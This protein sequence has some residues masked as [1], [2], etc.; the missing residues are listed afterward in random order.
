MAAT[1]L[2]VIVQGLLTGLVYGLMALGLSVIFGVMRVVNFAH[3]EF[4]VVAMYAAFILFEIL[5]LDPL[6]ALLPVAMLFFGVGYLLQRTLISPFIGRAEHEQFILLVGLATVIVNGLLMIFGPDARPINLSYSFDSYAVGGIFID[7]VRV[8]AAI[9]RPCGRRGIVPVLSL[10]P[11]RNRDPR[12]R[13]QPHGR[14]GGRPQC[15]AALRGDL[16]H[17][18]RLRRR[19]RHPDGDHRRCV[20]F[21]G[22]GL[23]PARLHHCDRRRARIDGRRADRRHPDRRL[24]STGR[25]LHSAVDEKHVLL[26]A[27]DHRAGAAS[28][29]IDGAAAVNGIWFRT[30]RHGKVLGLLLLF[31]FVVA[32]VMAD[33]YLLSV[34]ILVFYFAYLGQAWN[35]LMGFAGQLSLGH[36]LYLG[37]GAYTAT[38]L[39]TLFGIGPWLGVFVAIPVA[40]AAGLLIGWLGWRFAIEGV[41]FALLT[42]AF[43]EF[44]RIGF[45]N[46][47]VTGGAGG[48]FLPV[49]G[50]AAG[51]WWNLGGGPLL[52]YY[53]SLTLA[54]RGHRADR[55]T[56]PVSARL[57]LACRARGSAG[58]AGG[59]NQHLPRPHAGD[60]DLLRHDGGRR[61]VLRI[62]LSQPVS[63][64]GVRHQPLD[65]TDPGA[66]HWRAWYRVR[67]DR[68][69]DRADTARR[70]LDRPG[71]T[72]GRQ[73]ARRQGDLLWPHPDGDHLA[74]AQRRVAMAGA[75][76]RSRQASRMTGLLSV[77]D[78]SKRFRGL[79]AVSHVSFEVQP[80]EIFAV[81]G[82][83]GAGKTTLFNM[84]A[85]A[86]APD[87]GSIAFA[88]ERIDGLRADEIARLGIGRTFQLVKP[89]PALSVED[90]VVIGALMHAS[91]LPEARK[92]AHEIMSQL[93]LLGKRAQIASSLTLPDRKRLEV[94]R[95]LATRPRLL[96]LDEVMAG[97]RPTET[98]R[99]VGILRELNRDGLTVLLI[100]HVMRAVTALASNILVLHHGAAIAEGTPDQVLREPAVIQSYLGAEAL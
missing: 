38:A 57:P 20:A 62:L 11:Y 2:N 52:Y 81:I 7:K 87:G 63:I 97:L 24:G 43:A 68:R 64:A 39:W 73:R 88:G 4:T 58:G 50:E 21:A 69:R 42:I 94:A 18:P 61:S 41:Y 44:T 9:A 70:S 99:I 31:G 48:L 40:T 100:E 32:P 53:L 3:G 59:R 25:I 60:A 92:I 6:I 83:N 74:A 84:I 91:G 34:L 98:D 86:M 77:V 79:T 1:T 51:K 55:G 30:P 76:S 23:Y 72:P 8:L 46:L 15:Q 65:R 28:A 82:P 54:D 47:Q 22:A 13:R 85:G 10:H 36:A 17:R 89:F 56:A 14:R 45:D 93:D 71:A 75:S 80:G 12:L 27:A 49:N 26:C 19:R 37:L 95:A 90:N 67:A 66:D 96:L 5:H 78:V 16:R 33:R 29:G 35:L